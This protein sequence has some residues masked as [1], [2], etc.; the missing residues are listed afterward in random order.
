MSDDDPNGADDR[1]PV[2]CTITE[3]RAAERADWMTDALLP[4]YAGAEEREDGVTV[5]FDGTDETLLAVARF[6][7]EEK[8]CCAFADYRIDVSPPYD[9]T[10]LTVTGPEGTRELFA[11]EFVSRLEGEV[12]L[13]PPG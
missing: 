7:A 12:P 9:E 3:D 8:E 10:R 1:P 4:A 5:R 13:E 6:V 2:A 11:G